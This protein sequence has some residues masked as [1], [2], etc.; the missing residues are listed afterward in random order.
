MQNKLLIPI[1]FYHTYVILIFFGDPC[2]A[3]CKWPLETIWKGF[4]Q[5][6]IKIENEVL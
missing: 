1:Y 2:I 4:I 3:L 6:K 5:N